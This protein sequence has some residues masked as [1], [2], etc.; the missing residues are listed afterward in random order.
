MATV[1]LHI[2]NYYEFLKVTAHLKCWKHHIHSRAIPVRAQGPV[3]VCHR[4]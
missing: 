4:L 3:V 2:N 1:Q